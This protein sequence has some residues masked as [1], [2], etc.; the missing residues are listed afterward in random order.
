MVAEPQLHATGF[1]RR[2]VEILAKLKQNLVGSRF[3]RA[4]KKDKQTAECHS[5]WVHQAI[6]G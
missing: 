3:D 5:V 2:R 6:F 1:D 4:D